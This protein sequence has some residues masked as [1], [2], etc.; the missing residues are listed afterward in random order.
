MQMSEGLDEG[1]ILAQNHFPLIGSETSETLHDQ[2]AATG[3][4]LL[5]KTLAHL[6]EALKHAKPQDSSLVTYAPKIQKS[7]AE[8]DW[9]Q[10][11]VLIEQQI[12][13]FQP[14]PV[15]FSLLQGKVIR[16]FNASVLS[17]QTSHLAPGTIVENNLKTL[18]V[19]TGKDLLQI[20]QL[21]LPGKTIQPIVSVLNGYPTL[22]QPHQQFG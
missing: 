3:A 7:D 2:L 18:I 11:A 15:S 21:Q 10:P 14:W 6:K 12:R 13:A 17:G 22:F 4:K 8:I 5:I 1:D 20:H 9:S 16:F 19:S